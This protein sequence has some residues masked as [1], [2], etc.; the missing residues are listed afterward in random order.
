MAV[1]DE[2]AGRA[3]LVG[4]LL[5]AGL[6]P[7]LRDGHLLDDMTTYTLAADRLLHG[8]SIYA[9]FPGD[10]LPYKY[11]PWF[12]ALWV[13]LSFLP[14]ALLG[15]LWLGALLASAGWLLWRAPWWLALATGPFVAWGATIGNA[16]PLLFAVMA[17]ALPT[18]AAAIAIGAIASLKAFPILLVIPLI[19]QRRWREVLLAVAVALLLAAPMLLFD[20]SGYQVS[21]EGPMSINNILGPAAWVLTGGAAL[22]LAIVRPSFRTAGLAVMMGNPRFQFY[23]VGYL[24][25]GPPRGARADPASASPRRR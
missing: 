2:S 8:Q 23:D 6:A 3:L 5:I 10:L 15:A 19:A 11:A 4:G 20:L 24:L 1:F 13:P 9:S 16:A 25:I 18:R 22:V 12:A 14:G 17:A 21:A 7:T